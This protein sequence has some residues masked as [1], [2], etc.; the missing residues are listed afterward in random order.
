MLVDTIESKLVNRLEKLGEF[1]GNTPL[2]PLN[3]VF[4]K[5]G[6]KLYAKL[7]WQQI[8]ASVKARPAYYIFKDAFHSGELGNGRRL[9]DASSGNTAIAYAAIGAALNVPVTICL[10][11]NAS[12]VRKDMLKGFGTEIIF[13]SKFGGTDEAQEKAKY[14]H[15]QSPEKYYYADQYANENNWKAHYHGTGD[16]IFAQTSGEITHFVAGLGTTGTFTGTGRKL[17]ELIPDIRLISLQPD[18][19]LHGLEGWKHLETAIVPKIYDD[20]IADENRFIDT[21]DSYDWIKKVALKEGLLISPSA[22]ANLA[23]A[24][25]V[26][27]EIDQG[28]VVT[29]FPDNADKYGEVMKE[30]F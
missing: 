18:S 17:K 6:V 30:L 21:Y 9:L 27:N 5:T 24:I 14:L 22:A 25:K 19:A 16:E 26:A 10:P 3:N 1:V 15:D 29:V 7:E 4:Q 28:V 12:E 2:F 13:T 23:G 8:G 11:K 20:Q